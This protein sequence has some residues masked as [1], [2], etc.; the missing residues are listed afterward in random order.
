MEF[1][2]HDESKYELRYRLDLDGSLEF[3]K[4]DVRHC[5]TA[6]EVLSPRQPF[7]WLHPAAPIPFVHENQCW[8]SAALRDWPFHLRKAMR[9]A[10]HPGALRREILLA[11]MRARFQQSP[12]WMRRLAHVAYPVTCPDCPSDIYQALMRLP[13]ERRSHA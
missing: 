5:I 4:P 11:A 1:H 3:A 7:G 2:F 12:Q 13:A 6:I 9:N 10:L 8:T